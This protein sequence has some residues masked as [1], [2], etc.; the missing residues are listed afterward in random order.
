FAR[1]G[2]APGTDPAQV[3]GR[4]TQRPAPVREAL[5][6]GLDNWWLSALQGDP[7]SGD[8]LAAVLRAAGAEGWR[9]PGRRAV[10]RGDRRQLEELAGKE[11]ASH[12]PP[13]TLTALSRALHQLKAYDA[14]IALLRPAQRRHPSDFWIN[15]DLA[16]ALVARQP[17]NYPEALRFYSI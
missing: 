13:A 3:A 9:A 16:Y 15:L 10:A 17:P 14:V 11:A 4:I 7:A 12:Q 1:Y 8:W 2:I 5:V 6:A